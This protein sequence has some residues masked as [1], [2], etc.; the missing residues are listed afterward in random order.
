MQLYVTI[1]CNAKSRKKL[2]H[3]ICIISPSK[4]PRKI[5]H[6]TLLLNKYIPIDSYTHNK[7]LTS[8]ST[9][10]SLKIKENRKK[11]RYYCTRILN[12]FVSVIAMPIAFFDIF[13]CIYPISRKRC[14]QKT[15]FD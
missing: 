1:V 4:S 13:P 3:I 5:L 9:L 10:K 14:V 15:Q 11:E 12:V 7:Y 2:I 6:S 8:N